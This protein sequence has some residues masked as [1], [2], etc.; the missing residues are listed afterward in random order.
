[1]KKIVKYIWITSITTLSNMVMF[2]VPYDWSYGSFRRAV[3]QELYP[4]D[5]GAK[6]PSNISGMNLE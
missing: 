4:A 3:K 1:M 6:E 2:K 5:W